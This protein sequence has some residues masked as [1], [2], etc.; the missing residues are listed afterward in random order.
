MIFCYDF[1]RNL[2]YLVDQVTIFYSIK[3]LELFFIF[4]STFEILYFRC[5]GSHYEIPKNEI[6]KL[7]QKQY[8]E[9]DL[10]NKMICFARRK[11]IEFFLSRSGRSTSSPDL[12][13]SQ[14]IDIL[15]MFSRDEISSRIS[16]KMDE[17]ESEDNGVGTTTTLTKPTLLLLFLM[18]TMFSCCVRSRPEQ[19]PGDS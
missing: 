15:S 18:K 9:N 19:Q 6:M 10:L 4:T 5:C 17:N 11:V 8:F 1:C 16:E 3:K 14:A 2:I 13:N 12:P 7:C